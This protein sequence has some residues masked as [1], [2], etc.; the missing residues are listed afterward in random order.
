MDPTLGR[1]AFNIGIFL[2]F[3]AVIPLPFLNVESAEFVV[4][5]I[6]LIV[7]LAFLIFVTFDVKRQV[8]IL[9]EK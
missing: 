6:A 9:K 1:V 5:I 7:S 3:L 2:V 4:D 8:K